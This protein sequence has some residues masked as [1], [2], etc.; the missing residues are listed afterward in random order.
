MDDMKSLAD[1]ITEKGNEYEFEEIN[2]D[3]LIGL[4]NGEPRVVHAILERTAIVYPF[5]DSTERAVR[6]LGLV[7]VWPRDIVWR[8]RSR[9]FNKGFGL[10]NFNSSKFHKREQKWQKRLSIL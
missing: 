1:I 8:Q 9:V 10:T 6:R 7:M 5:S 4:V 2:P 3:H